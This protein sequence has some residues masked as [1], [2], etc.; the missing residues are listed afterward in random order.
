MRSSLLLLDR[1][2][3]LRASPP[4]GCSPMRFGAWHP[5]LTCQAS[6]NQGITHGELELEKKCPCIQHGAFVLTL[7]SGEQKHQCFWFTV[8]SES[9]HYRF[10]KGV[11]FFAQ[12][13]FS[14]KACKAPENFE[15]EEG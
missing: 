13:F 10:L 12:L 11:K 5:G 15:S 4:F 1:A 3:S 14:H 6:N 8:P 7:R 2:S 9:F